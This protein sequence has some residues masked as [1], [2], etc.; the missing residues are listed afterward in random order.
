[1]DY[2]S[3]RRKSRE[4]N[5]GSVAIGGK[6]PIS[7]QS[8]TN[9][10]TH[11][12]ESTYRQIKALSDAGCDIVRLALPDI[13]SAKTISELKKRGVEIPLV[14]DIHFDYKIALVMLL[15]K[16]AAPYWVMLLIL[17]AGG[18]GIVAYIIPHVLKGGQC[19]TVIGTEGG[20]V[21]HHGGTTDIGHGAYRLLLFKPARYLPGGIFTHAVAENVSA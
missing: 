17:Y 13:E 6:H 9:T 1:M 5:I 21:Y 15:Y 8:M 4:F 19:H 10:D 16:G 20:L 11:D 2:N 18:I 7:I 3:F 14:A 12:L